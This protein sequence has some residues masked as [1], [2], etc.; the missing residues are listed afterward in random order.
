MVDAATPG[1]GPASGPSKGSSTPDPFLV[2]A[3]VPLA[4][5]VGEEGEPSELGAELQHGG[6]ID[7]ETVRRIACDATVV[8]AVDDRWATPCTRGGPSASL[9]GPNDER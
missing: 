2:V 4:D 3:H 8:V 5:L 1:P 7:L 9:L 6:L